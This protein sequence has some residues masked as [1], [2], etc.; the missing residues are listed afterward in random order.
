M[1]NLPR[2][3]KK[4]IEVTLKQFRLPKWWRTAAGSGPWLA[5]PPSPQYQTLLD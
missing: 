1:V 3:A 5:P 4:P 2:G